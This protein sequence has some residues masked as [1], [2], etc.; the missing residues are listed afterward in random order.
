[1]RLTPKKR[2]QPDGVSDDDVSDDDESEVKLE[3]VKFG[4]EQFQSLTRESKNIVLRSEIK[5][6]REQSAKKRKENSA[7]TQKV[8]KSSRDNTPV[9]KT[10]SLLVPLAPHSSKVQDVGSHQKQ[11]QRK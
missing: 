10:S 9:K 1:M 7:R 4:S 3:D 2:Q 6:K 11:L 8:L 5:M